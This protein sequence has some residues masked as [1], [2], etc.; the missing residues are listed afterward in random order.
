MNESLVHRMDVIVD[1]F[2]DDCFNCL[3]ILYLRPM[4]HQIHTDLVYGIFDRSILWPVRR[5]TNNTVPTLPH[6]LV[7]LRR[8]VRG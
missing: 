2:F 8:L 6:G 4:L 3:Q 7:N 5:M 1:D